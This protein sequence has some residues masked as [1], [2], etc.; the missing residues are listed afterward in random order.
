M[1]GNG[2]K[3]LKMANKANTAKLAKIAILER[4]GK[5]RVS[6]DDLLALPNVRCEDPWLFWNRKSKWGGS[7]YNL[8]TLCQNKLDN[9]LA[10]LFFIEDAYLKQ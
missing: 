8:L 2:W 5:G 10:K 9:I 3:Q 1:D 4:K 7:S 6:G